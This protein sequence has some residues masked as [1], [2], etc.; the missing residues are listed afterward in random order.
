M[1]VLDDTVRMVTLGQCEDMQT[2]SECNYAITN[3]EKRHKYRH[4]YTLSNVKIIDK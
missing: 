3:T 2:S 4:Y 1:T